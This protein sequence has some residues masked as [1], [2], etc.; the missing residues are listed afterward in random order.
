MRRE[1]GCARTCLALSRRDRKG[2]HP[3]R[4]R[5][6]CQYNL[7]M[8]PPLLRPL[9]RHTDSLM[10]CCLPSFTTLFQVPLCVD[11]LAE[12]TK[13]A[14]DEGASRIFLASHERGRPHLHLFHF[15]GRRRARC[16]QISPRARPFSP[17]TH[18]RSLDRSPVPAERPLR[19]PQ[20]VALT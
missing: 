9:K 5:S 19:L 16:D 6:P 4:H 2:R 1:A 8:P 13:S 14:I 17:S 7:A 20:V 15:F 12:I 11:G 3:W 18:A 10:F